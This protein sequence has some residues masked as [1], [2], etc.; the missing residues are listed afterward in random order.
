M[1]SWLFRLVVWSIVESFTHRVVTCQSHIGHRSVKVCQQ[2][3]DHPNHWAMCQLSPDVATCY[4]LYCDCL[5]KVIIEKL[6]GAQTNN[7]DKRKFLIPSDISISQLVWIIRKRVHLESEKALFL[8][9]D[10][11]IPSSRLASFA[12]L[13]TRFVVFCCWKSDQNAAFSDLCWMLWKKHCFIFCKNRL[14]NDIVC[15]VGH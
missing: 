13:H 7:L 12:M 10:K 15:G 8:F 4:L 6:P 9:V 5:R 3:T 2:K 1:D 11:T 14:Q